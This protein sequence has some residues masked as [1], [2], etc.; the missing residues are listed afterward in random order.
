MVIQGAGGECALCARLL[1][2]R[3]LHTQRVLSEDLLA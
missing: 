3:A 1:V 2:P